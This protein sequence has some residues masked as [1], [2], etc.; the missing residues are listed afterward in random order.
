MN[1]ILLSVLMVTYNH[2]KYIE[3]AIES[4]ANQKTKYKIELLIGDD[5]S[6]DNTP[7]IIQRMYDRYPEII[8]PILRNKN[9]GGTQNAFDLLGKSK[10]KYIAFCDGDD[11]W[12]IGN[13]I[14]AQID[15]LEINKKYSAINGKCLVIDEFGKS[16]EEES[17]RKLNFWQYSEKEYTVKNFEKWE[18]PGHNSALIGRNIFRAGNCDMIWKASE[19]VGDRSQTLLFLQEGPIY[20]SDEIVSKYRLITN[21]ENFVSRYWKDNLRF[22]DYKMMQNLEKLIFE[23][24]GGKV[25]LSIPKR[26]RFIGAVVVWMKDKTKENRD[27]V[28]NIIKVCDNKLSYGFLF[29]KVVM[30]KLFYWKIL[31]SDRNI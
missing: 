10:G 1:N 2:E 21:G 30:I 11:E 29:V 15:F 8:V 16:V 18:M 23:T 13:R 3:N 14:D 12:I 28:K 22:E 27:V 5:A 25:D 26:Q 17:L 9:I 24:R 7:Q 4:I 19:I 6:T 20:C 31:K